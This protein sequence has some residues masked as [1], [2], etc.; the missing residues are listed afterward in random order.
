MFPVT[1][2]IRQYRI[3]QIAKND[4]II[5]YRFSFL[6]LNETIPID[7]SSIK[8]SHWGYR[9]CKHHSSVPE[10]EKELSEIIETYKEAKTYPIEIKIS[11]I[12]E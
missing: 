9:G 5:Q 10:A 2:T 1:K 11:E 4:Y 8:W 3:L 12:I 6:G 7:K